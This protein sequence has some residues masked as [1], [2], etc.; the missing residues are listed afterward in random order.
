ML[1]AEEPSVKV[2][3]LA[4]VVT[5]LYFYMA[6]GKITTRMAFCCV[7]S[8]G[9]TQGKLWSFVKTSVILHNLLRVSIGS[10]T[11]SKT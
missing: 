11:Y 9:R 5:I 3:L 7:L 10:Q 1:L 6:S 8:V 4:S 2:Y